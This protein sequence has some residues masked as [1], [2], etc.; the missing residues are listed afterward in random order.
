MDLHNAGHID[1]LN[2]NDPYMKGVHTTASQTYYEVPLG[3]SVDEDASPHWSVVSSEWTGKVAATVTDESG[4]ILGRKKW[5]KGF[6]GI[7][8]AILPTQ[9]EEF[10]HI[11]GLADYAVTVAGGQILNNMIGFGL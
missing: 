1:V 6:I 8:G 11:Y 4:V 2:F 7:F 3:Y 10:D 5:G 9:T